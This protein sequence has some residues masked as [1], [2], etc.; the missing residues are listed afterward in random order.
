MLLTEPPTVDGNA[1]NGASELDVIVAQR[2]AGK[3]FFTVDTNEQRR[4]FF[5]EH[6]GAIGPIADVYNGHRLVGS[7]P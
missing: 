2:T 3:S 4:Q 7:K 6:A 1:A 5:L